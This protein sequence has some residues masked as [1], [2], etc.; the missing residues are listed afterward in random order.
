VPRQELSE[1]E[2]KAWALHEEALGL[3]YKRQFREAQEAFRKVRQLLPKDQVS[4]SFIER[5]QACLSHPPGK[6]WTG[7]VI[8]TE[9]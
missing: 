9:K 5:C 6:D 7:A 1:T 4:A 8:M 3:Y 2:A